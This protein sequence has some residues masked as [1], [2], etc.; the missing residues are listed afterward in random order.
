MWRSCSQ[1]NATWQQLEVECD[2]RRPFSETEVFH[3]SLVRAVVRFVMLSRIPRLNDVSDW[4]AGMNCRLTWRENNPLSDHFQLSNRDSSNSQCRLRLRWFLDRA[5]LVIIGLNEISN[6]WKISLRIRPR[7][8]PSYTL[9]KSMTIA[10]INQKCLRK[11]KFVIWFCLNEANEQKKDEH[12][13]E[14]Q[15]GASSA[16]TPY[17]WVQCQVREYHCKHT[18]E[19]SSTRR[20]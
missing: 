2:A 15:S 11:L 19:H 16:F 20:R 6:S 8:F 10:Y 5:H 18:V 17:A 1:I 4:E 12:R 14:K 3:G 9:A 7:M 13:W